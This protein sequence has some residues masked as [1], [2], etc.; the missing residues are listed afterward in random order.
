VA[1]NAAAIT[2]LDDAEFNCL[3]Q[4]QAVESSEQFGRFAPEFGR[5]APEWC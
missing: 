2:S 1:G 3:A 4:R 5:F